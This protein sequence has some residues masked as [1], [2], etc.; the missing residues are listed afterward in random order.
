MVTAEKFDLSK[1]FR[2][3][4]GDMLVDDT[5]HTRAGHTKDMRMAHHLF[6]RLV[7]RFGVHTYVVARADQA[8]RN[9]LL[10]DAVSG[11]TDLKRILS[12]RQRRMT[13]VDS[14]GEFEPETI[15]ELFRTRLETLKYL[16]QLAPD[17]QSVPQLVRMYQRYITSI[18]LARLSPS[19]ARFFDCV[20]SLIRHKLNS[21]T[22]RERI[23]RFLGKRT[24]EVAISE[25]IKDDVNIQNSFDYE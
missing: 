17:E 24:E 5:L 11:H 21:A 4:M 13:F 15:P 8:P 10:L 12:G 2:L 3:L 20:E 23:R 25:D 19:E 16:L 18:R 7:A 14:H 1:S 6:V 22:R 9:V